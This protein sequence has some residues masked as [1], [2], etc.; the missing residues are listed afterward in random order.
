M[1]GDEA[2]RSVA[3]RGGAR[4]RE[5]RTAKNGRVG[6]ILL[7][8]EERRDG[9]RSGNE[10]GG[11]EQSRGVPS[12]GPS[13]DALVEDDGTSHDRRPLPRRPPRDERVL[14]WATNRAS[15]PRTLV[16]A[17][18]SKSDNKIKQEGVNWLAAAF[19]GGDR[20][21]TSAT[22]VAAGRCLERTAFRRRSSQKVH[23]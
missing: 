17:C 20:A 10:N 14:H 16:T 13:C 12:R 5:R 21:S 23:K 6:A 9:V 2:W 3:T 11:E 4:R 7:P 8:G 22:G 19:Q 15:E 1:K 18:C